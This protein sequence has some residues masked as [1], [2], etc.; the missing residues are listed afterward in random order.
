MPPRVFLC[1]RREDASGH[2]GR[3]YDRL[4]EHFGEEQIFRD[5]DTIEPGLDFAEVIRTTVSAC[6]VLVAVI[7]RHW[8][9][10]DHGVWMILAIGFQP[11][12]PQRC[13]AGSRIIPVLVD[14]AAMPQ[15]KDLPVDIAWLARRHAVVLTDEGWREDVGRLLKTLE[16][17]ALAANCG[18]RHLPERIRNQLLWLS[19][20]Q[21]RQLLFEVR[22]LAMAT[23]A[24]GDRAESGSSR[25]GGGFRRGWDGARCATHCTPNR[26]R[27]PSWA[28]AGIAAHLPPPESQELV[29][30]AL[31]VARTARAIEGGGNRKWHWREWRLNCGRARCANRCWTRRSTVAHSLASPNIVNF[32]AVHLTP[33]LAK[34]GRLDDALGIA[35]GITDHRERDKAV[36]AVSA[37]IAGGGIS[38]GCTTD[39]SRD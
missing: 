1:Y 15:D 5:V 14:R 25:A 21:R 31:Q 11:R 29:R 6:D 13:S 22:Q 36:A 2:A 12:S 9:A 23:E 35:L 16:K 39:R 24:D 8:Q 33:L 30:E 28:L 34:A 32:A 38:R 19:Q 20:G 37:E 3:L 17:I 27:T 7:G 10:Q 4:S 26:L 18:M